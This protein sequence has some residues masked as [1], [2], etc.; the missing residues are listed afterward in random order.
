MRFS[1]LAASSTLLAISFVT[2]AVAAP[3]S[4]PSALYLQRCVGGLPWEPSFGFSL[5]SWL[6]SGARSGI[7]S[8]WTKTSDGWILQETGHD[9]LTQRQVVWRFELVTEVNNP[10]SPAIDPSTLHYCDEILANRVF[11]RRV[12]QNG[13]VLTND[14]VSTLIA[15]SL[16]NLVGRDRKPAPAP[17]PLPPEPEI[18]IT[19]EMLQQSLADPAAHPGWTATNSRTVCY[20]QT[21]RIKNQTSKTL[22]F[23]MLRNAKRANLPMD[24]EGNLGMTHP[25]ETVRWRI[26][27]FA[28]SFIGIDWSVKLYRLF[29]PAD[30]PTASAPYPN[31]N[32][33]RNLPED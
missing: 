24:V 4:G 22:N 9:Q 27:D 1:I 15:E 17:A 25:G 33:R 12:S 18:V 29:S 32:D 6:Q 11:I 2:P 23:F 14:Q 10:Q 28:T 31:P 30:C 8:S 20:P 3:E 26:A 13:I 7:A 21:I 19:D 5:R 16:S